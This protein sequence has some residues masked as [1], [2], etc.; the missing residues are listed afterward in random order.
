MADPE[1]SPERLSLVSFQTALCIV[2]PRHLWQDIDRLRSLYDQA[3]GRWPPHINLLY[4]FV[5]ADQLPVASKL[6]QDALSVLN[7][8]SESSKIHLQS[9]PAGYFRIRGRNHTIHLTLKDE[10]KAQLVKFRTSVLESLGQ[11]GL[12][13]RQYCPHLTVGQTKPD[14]DLRD[15]L[16]D[17]VNKLP[18]I[19]CDLGHLVILHREKEGGPGGTSRM[20]IWDAIDL[21]GNNMS[22]SEELSRLYSGISLHG[23]ETALD[24]PS[25]SVPTEP[26][27]TYEFSTDRRSWNPITETSVETTNVRTNSLA[28]STYNVLAESTQPPPRDRYDLLVKHILSTHALAD[29]L[30]LQEVCDDFLIFLLSRDDIRRRYPFVT[31]GPPGQDGIPPLP[32]L[33]NIV[34]FSQWKFTWAWLPFEARH[35][36]AA[37]LKLDGTGDL[38]SSLPTVIAAVHLSSGLTDATVDSKMSQIRTILSL[39][40]KDYPDNPSVIAG[41]FN[42]ATSQEVIDTSL[43]QKTISSASVEKIMG[44]NYL[45]SK[46]QF[47]DGWAVSCAEFGDAP[48]DP[49]TDDSSGE[50][51]H[52]AT[53]DP[54]SNPL[55]AQS[56]VN[57]RPQR[58]DRIFVRQTGKSTVTDFNF[59]G[60]PDTPEDGKPSL[61]E[62]ASDHWGIR[63]QVQIGR[64]LKENKATEAVSKAAPLELKEVPESL[65]A[66]EGL[67]SGLQASSMFPGEG[68][69]NTRKSIVATLTG[70]LTEPIHDSNGRDIKTPLVLIPV[71]SYGLGTW[72]PNSDIDCLCIG[73][74]SSSTF[75][76]LAIQRLRRASAHGIR[77]S[78]KVKAATGTMLELQAGNIKLDLQYCPAAKI[79]E[80][81]QE[82][83]KLPPQDPIFDLSFYS[84][85]KLQPFR[86]QE[87]LKRTIPDL[88]IF[89]LAHR[90]ITLWAK[91]SGVYS[92]KFGLL[93]GIHITMMLSRL[94]QLLHEDVGRVTAP[95]LV[96]MFFR[97]YAN[98]DWKN[99]IVDIPGKQSKYRRSLR[100]PMVILTVHTPTINVA[101]AVTAPSLRTIVSALKR[102]EQLLAEDGA[103][104]S[105]ILSDTSISHNNQTGA[106]KFLVTY[107]NYIKVNVQYWGPSSAQ[108]NSLVGWLESRFFRLLNDLDKNVPG[109]HGRIW[110]ARF[111]SK[112]APDG[113]DEGE[114]EY[115]GCYLVG[116]ERLQSATNIVAEDDKEA[117]RATM[118]QF[119]V[120]LHEE[121][122]YFDS[123]VCWIDTTHVKQAE[124][125]E[126]RLDHRS[127]GE[128]GGG[129]MGASDFFSDED[130]DEDPDEDDEVTSAFFSE[131][132][133]VNKAKPRSKSTAPAS[134]PVSTNKLRPAAD[135][136]S[137]LRWD[138][139]IDSGDYIVGYEDRFLGEKETPLSRWKSEQTDEEFIPQH[140]II[141][142]KRKSDGRRVWDR[143]TRKDEIFGSGIGGEKLA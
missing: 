13:E 60:L 7:Q 57:G 11:H 129:G 61:S 135:I 101:R 119:T 44:L 39:L 97:H 138:P 14:D 22:N 74:I 56:S 18:A 92:S 3:Y 111:T 42:F 28:V 75:F 58:Y 48:T 94:H 127:W 88:H 96:S 81:W 83:A 27:T 114:T 130:A 38:I 54:I 45:L 142:F 112:D 100:E 49:V 141:Y 1:S 125:G 132:H 55:A 67:E 98:F 24:E 131:E 36:G 136:I 78:R 23:L 137:R 84:L 16:L 65:S 72:N 19:Q 93:G 43:K 10:S 33:R 99:K 64:N 109:V 107:N 8:S 123:T 66:S 116:L 17:K 120:S 71:G 15:F 31:H 80:R 106:D 6:I 90:C 70:I 105:N 50:G 29:V 12:E 69:I 122:K 25:H 103:T 4:P 9:G 124:L 47:M 104:W 85:M 126:L 77:I 82:A 76:S 40:D 87:Y 86:D 46:A 134:K 59:F 20:V 121:T 63:A 30:V 113:A 2:P 34:V 133:A 73:A 139:K 5:A 95:E 140:R 79:A 37:I 117:L 115:Q 21:S 110:P 89:R 143:E 68:D 108:A 35:K 52:G 53:F 102:A 26:M 32:S 128:Q 41:D 51:E 62:F 118:G 91:S